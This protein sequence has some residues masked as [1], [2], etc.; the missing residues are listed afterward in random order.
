MYDFDTQ[1]DLFKANDARW[2]AL[3]TEGLSLG[4]EQYSPYL[5]GGHA[6]IVGPDY[7]GGGFVPVHGD[8]DPAQD[9][10]RLDTVPGLPAT[11]PII[12]GGLHPVTEP[13]FGSQVGHVITTIASD[14]MTTTNTT[15]PDHWFYDGK[16]VNRLTFDDNGDAFVT[17][18]GFGNSTAPLMDFANQAA[19]PWIFER[20]H[21]DMRAYL[22]RRRRG[23]R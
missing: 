21:D 1:A 12:D 4:D 22:E 13:V 7:I 17:T 19:G 14:G 6:F 5:P 3:N 8:Y 23:E 15:A 20:M 11:V 16:I 2:W 18:Y 10:L 9:A